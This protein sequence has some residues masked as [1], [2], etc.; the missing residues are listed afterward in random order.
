MLALFFSPFAGYYWFAAT[1][2]WGMSDGTG[3]ESLRFAGQVFRAWWIVAITLVP[4]TIYAKSVGTRLFCAFA[5]L[6]Y[7]VPGLLIV[8]RHH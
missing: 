6:V 8:Y 7:W 1:M 3:S 4:M 2:A 5:T